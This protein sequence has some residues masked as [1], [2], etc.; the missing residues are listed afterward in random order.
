MAESL[1][2]KGWPSNPFPTA[3]I[4]QALLRYSACATRGPQKRCPRSASNNFRQNPTRSALF[5]SWGKG[6]S[7]NF[8]QISLS[9]KACHSHMPKGLPAPRCGDLSHA[10]CSE[11]LRRDA[12]PRGVHPKNR[13]GRSW[14]HSA[15]P[16]GLPRGDAL[17]EQVS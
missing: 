17:S 4:T 16:A 8:R 10:D 13:P 6:M 12:G 7:D 14:R 1:E 15:E 9:D 2:R 3:V 11:Q 5:I